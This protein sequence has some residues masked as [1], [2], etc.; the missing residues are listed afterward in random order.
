MDYVQIF[1]TGREKKVKFLLLLISAKLANKDV[2]LESK[3]TGPYAISAN[4]PNGTYELE[5]LD[6]NPFSGLVSDSRIKRY[7]FSRICK[8]DDVHLNEDVKNSSRKAA[9]ILQNDNAPN[10]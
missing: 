8:K 10:P 1:V 6:G 7:N 2:K 9:V 4:G 5:A 3:W